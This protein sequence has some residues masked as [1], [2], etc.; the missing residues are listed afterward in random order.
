MTSLVY[1]WRSIHR[2]PWK[3]AQYIFTSFSVIFTL[4]RAITYFIP[5][6][7]IEGLLPLAAAAVVSVVFGLGKAW[8]P[9]R[10]E[11]PIANCNT[12]IEVLF[13]DLFAQ[14]GIRVVAVNEFFDS[15]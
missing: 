14:D 13:G 1:L 8:K 15:K 2:R 10:I 4:V 6:I 12:A 7:K 3:T 9:S 5:T 11:I